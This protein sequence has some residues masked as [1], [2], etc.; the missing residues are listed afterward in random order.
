MI[1]L[2]ASQGVMAAII[3]LTNRYF[4]PYQQ[5]MK[6]LSNWGNSINSILSALMS[7][8]RFG[9]RDPHTDATMK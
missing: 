9:R 4:A 3:M 8:C 6:T 7:Y 2:D 5:V 1:N